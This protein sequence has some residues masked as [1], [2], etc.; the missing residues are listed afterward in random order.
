MAHTTGSL[1]IFICGWVMAKH[2]RRVRYETLRCPETPCLGGVGSFPSRHKGEYFGSS[3][4]VRD[5]LCS[6]RLWAGFHISEREPDSIVDFLKSIWFAPCRGEL[7]W[8]L[9][10]DIMEDFVHCFG[11]VCDNAPY[12]QYIVDMKVP[13]WDIRFPA[14]LPSSFMNTKHGLNGTEFAPFHCPCA[15]PS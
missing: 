9:T 10:W 4:I 3:S 6:I 12:D 15:L 8:I 5:S 2:P 1:S 7:R 11:K 14:K 13:G